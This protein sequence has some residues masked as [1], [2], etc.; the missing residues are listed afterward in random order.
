MCLLLPLHMRL[1]QR[2]APWCAQHWMRASRSTASVLEEV[3]EHPVPSLPVKWSYNGTRPYWFL[4]WLKV[5]FAVHGDLAEARSRSCFS[6]FRHYCW[7]TAEVLSWGLP[8]HSG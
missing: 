1:S 7:S 2:R 8:V 6:F 3:A 5:V 4:Q